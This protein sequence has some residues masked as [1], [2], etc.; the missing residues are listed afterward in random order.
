[1]GI[2]FTCSIRVS[3]LRR[4]CLSILSIIIWLVSCG[5]L[6]CVSIRFLS[7]DE[8]E[9]FFKGLGSRVRVGKWI[10]DSRI[11]VF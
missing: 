1:M 5:S 10:I 4:C 3:L 2:V 8:I 11:L 6:I 9:G 7:G